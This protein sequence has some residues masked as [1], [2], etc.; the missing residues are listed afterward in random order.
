MIHYAQ[1]D[2]NIIIILQLYSPHTATLISSKTSIEKLDSVA[3]DTLSERK[4]GLQNL[5]TGL[6]H[7]LLVENTGFRLDL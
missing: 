6:Y 2:N 5:Q 1:I 3:K 4:A 7:I